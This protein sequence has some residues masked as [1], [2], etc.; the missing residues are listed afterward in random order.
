[1]KLLW[2]IIAAYLLTLA[3]YPCSEGRL[4]AT[5]ENSPE[6]HKQGHESKQCSPFCIC[7]HCPASAMYPTTSIEMDESLVAISYSQ[8]PSA[9]SFF[10]TKNVSFEIWQPP[11][12]S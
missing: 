8:Q 5:V 12:I 6:N 7:A 9:Y 1:M 2:L 4:C 11:K 10:F 3:V